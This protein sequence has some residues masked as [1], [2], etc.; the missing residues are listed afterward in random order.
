LIRDR[1]DGL[2]VDPD[3]PE[4]IGA[5]IVRLLA[6]DQTATGLGQAGQ[7]RVRDH[8]SLQVLVPQNEEFYASCL[9]RQKG[10][11]NGASHGSELTWV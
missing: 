7:A 6:D 10:Y 5:A 11:G 1:R 8:F 9:E 3:R 4:E 2:L